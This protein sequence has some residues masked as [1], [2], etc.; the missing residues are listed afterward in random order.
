MLQVNYF[1]WTNIQKIKNEEIKRRITRKKLPLQAKRCLLQPLFI[2]TRLLPSLARYI[3]S[4]ALGPCWGYELSVAGM[5][6]AKT[7]ASQEG[8]CAPPMRQTFSNNISK[9]G[10]SEAAMQTLSNYCCGPVIAPPKSCFNNMKCWTALAYR[11]EGKN[12]IKKHWSFFFSQV[13]R[14]L[15]PQGMSRGVVEVMMGIKTDLMSTQKQECFVKPRSMGRALWICYI[16][17]A[18]EKGTSC[19]LFALKWNIA[20]ET[21]FT[22]FYYLGQLTQHVCR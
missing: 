13:K 22:H 1:I 10:E 4:H 14:A 2:I 9:A 20:P 12:I 5:A 21:E 17:L 18:T 16:V 15:T 3:W 19:F 7:Q 11:E 6:W 8:P